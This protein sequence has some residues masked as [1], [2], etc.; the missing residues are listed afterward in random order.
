MQGPG[1]EKV[2]IPLALLARIIEKKKSL[3]SGQGFKKYEHFVFCI[4][5]KLSWKENQLIFN[6]NQEISAILNETVLEKR[7]YYLSLIIK[8]QAIRN[9]LPL[10]GNWNYDE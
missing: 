9:E 1:L 8:N 4:N 2:V 10:H 3:Y 5:S 6:K 7:Y